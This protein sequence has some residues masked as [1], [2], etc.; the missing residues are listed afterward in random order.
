[1]IK[2]TEEV[3]PTIYHDRAEIKARVQEDV[4]RYDD[5]YSLDT[6]VNDYTDITEFKYYERTNVFGK[7]I[8][9]K[10]YTVRGS[11]APREMV[12]HLNGL[13]LSYPKI[14][15]SRDFNK[16]DEFIDNLKSEL[17]RR[18]ELMIKEARSIVKQHSADSN[19]DMK[20]LKDIQACLKRYL[21]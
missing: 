4:V 9:R 1:M 19:S 13:Y 21:Q 11:D 5:I 8:Y 16:F 17:D 12:Q 7:D 3:A 20:D 15:F 2:P 10:E 18:L 14:F 6:Y